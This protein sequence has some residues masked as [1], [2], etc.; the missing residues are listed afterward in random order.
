LAGLVI[1][2]VGAVS[3]TAGVAIIDHEALRYPTSIAV[4]TTISFGLTGMVAFAVASISRSSRQCLIISALGVAAF[5]VVFNM[6]ETARRSAT[7]TM[8]LQYA[9]TSLTILLFAAVAV[10]V[11]LNQ[12]LA[13]KRMR[14][15]I[16]ALLGLAASVLLAVNWPYAWPGPT[17]EPEEN[18]AA[19]QVVELEWR[20]SSLSGKG[21]RQMRLGYAVN[22]I[23]PGTVASL[24]P[25]KHVWTLRG[26]GGLIR[27]WFTGKDYSLRSVGTL[28]SSSLLSSDAGKGTLQA[29]G[30]AP[31]ELWGRDVETYRGVLP[32]A[33][34]SKTVTGEFPVRPGTDVRECPRRIQILEV[35]GKAPFLDVTIY[36]PRQTDELYTE[37]AVINRRLDRHAPANSWSVSRGFSSASISKTR[38]QKFTVVRKESDADFW[39]DATL[40]EVTFRRVAVIHRTVEATG[41]SLKPRP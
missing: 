36:G 11:I 8:D 25:S 7:V 12:F 28:E 24:L 35:V 41:D 2:L 6:L 17:L 39:R 30:V 32:I 33:L 23:P 10:F 26:T 21:G 14:S 13:R 29:S 31:A 1:A 38:S 19:F 15:I 20:S 18:A 3:A 27:C 16:V 5:F 4:V 37:Y 22:N 34:W 9:R 40:V